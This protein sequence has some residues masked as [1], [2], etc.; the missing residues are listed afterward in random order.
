ML[1]PSAVD[2]KRRG[3]DFIESETTAFERILHWNGCFGRD[4][5]DFDRA[6]FFASVC[7]HIVIKHMDHLWKSI[8]ALAFAGRD[9]FC[10]FGKDR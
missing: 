7:W 5:L 2:T 9:V 10:F 6:S 8:P 3:G 1:P 4:R